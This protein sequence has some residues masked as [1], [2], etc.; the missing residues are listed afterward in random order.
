MVALIYFHTTL[1]I[2]SEVPFLKLQL[3][4]IERH[5]MDFPGHSPATRKKK[6]VHT[7]IA[8]H[9]KGSVKVNQHYQYICDCTHNK[10]KVAFPNNNLS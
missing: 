4:A 1:K 8:L 6:Q 2:K 3:C 10:V 5:N 9:L 7:K